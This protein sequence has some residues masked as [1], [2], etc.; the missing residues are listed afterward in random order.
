M[1]IGDIWQT[2]LE[3]TYLGEKCVNVFNWRQADGDPALTAGNVLEA[4]QVQCL[5]A[6]ADIMD[7]SVVY[8]RILCVNMNTPS[9]NAEENTPTPSTGGLADKTPAPAFIA[10]SYRSNRAGFGTRYSYKRFAGMVL[11]HFDGDQ[12]TTAAM[13]LFATVTPFLDA[14][15]YLGTDLIACQVKSGWHIGIAPVH[16]FDC[17]SWTAQTNL[18]T[19]VSRKEG[20]GD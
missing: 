7:D 15:S 20:R 18:S 14:I 16:N 10:V 5:S 2:R 6:I 19:Q 4:F 17:T 13:T 1:A 3:Y 9:N 11:E 12:W 8:N